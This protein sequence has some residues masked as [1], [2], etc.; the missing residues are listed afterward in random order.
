MIPMA[1]GSWVINLGR[2]STEYIEALINLSH[3]KKAGIA[4][5]L[6]ALKIDADGPVKIQPYGSLFLVTN[7]AHHTSLPS[8]DFVP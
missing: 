1:M 5:D 6:C 4:G 8:D 7:R 3:E 2:R